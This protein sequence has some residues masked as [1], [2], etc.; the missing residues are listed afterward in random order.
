MKRLFQSQSQNLSLRILPQCKIKKAENLTIK[1]KEVV[2]RRKRERSRKNRNR[3]KNMRA[4][5]VVS[6][7]L[8]NN[9]LSRI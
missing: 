7:V 9:L 1:N 8:R 2:I 6:M 4:N 5:T 3:M